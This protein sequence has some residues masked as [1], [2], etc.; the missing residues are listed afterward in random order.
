M[1]VRRLQEGH[2]VLQEG[3]RVIRQVSRAD[4]VSS[5]LGLSALPTATCGYRARAAARTLPRGN[6]R[7]SPER[8]RHHLLGRQHSFGD[9]YMF[10]PAR[11]SSISAPANTKKKK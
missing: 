7:A 4:V 6:P 1:G 3:K 5:R 9:L 11:T 8:P 2:G 10:R